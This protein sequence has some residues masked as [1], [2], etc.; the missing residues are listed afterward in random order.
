VKL[1]GAVKAIISRKDYADAGFAR[2]FTFFPMTMDFLS[3]SWTVS[4]P[5]HF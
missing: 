2:P 3:R 4:A 1:K 5:W